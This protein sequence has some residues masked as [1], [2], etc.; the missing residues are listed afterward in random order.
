MRNGPREP[1]R[2]ARVALAFVAILAM[3]AC[4]GSKPPAGP[5]TNPPPGTHG[6][7]MSATI[8]GVRWN[9]TVISAAAISG[10]VLRIAGQDRTTAP[11]IALGLATP[12]AVGTYTVSAANGATVAGSLDQV[13][14]TGA[15][16]LQW[17]ANFTFGSGTVTLSTLT[18]TSASGTFSFTL[19][20]V[21]TQSTGQ[22]VITNGVF[23]ITF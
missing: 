23:N 8:D 13:T 19:V 16:P 21:A 4:T 12:P 20:H 1:L 11:F 3:T 18:S 2:R 15:A 9:S 5:S 22:K 7:S 17:N 6:G 14:A 10:G